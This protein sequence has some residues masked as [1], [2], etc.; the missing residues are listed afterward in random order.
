[1]RLRAFQQRF[2][3]GALKPECRTAVLSLPRGNGK[4]SLVAM[5]AE[6]CLTP[7]DRLHVPG[8]E[9][10]IV[11]GSLGQARRTT[12]RLLKERMVDRDGY[13]IA[14]SGQACHVYH[15][16]SDCRISVLPAN[17]RGAQGLV[18]APWVFADDCGSWEANGGL[19]MYDAIQTSMGKPD[20]PMTAIYT[21]TIAP[22]VRGWWPELATSK[23]TR[24]TFVMTLQADL[25]KWDSLRELRRV[26]PLLWQFPDSRAVVKDELQKAKTDSRLR[27]RFLSY[28]ANLPTPDEASVLLPLS[29]WAMVLK[30]P[31]PPPDDIGAFVG[32]DVGSSR[33]WSAACATWLSGRAEAFAM[34]GGI[35]SLEARERRD[36]VPR[37]LYA[38]LARSGALVVQPERRTV[39]MK[40]FAEEIA[41]RWDPIL[42]TAD[43][44]RFAALKDECDFPLV[45]ADSPWKSH[46][47]GIACLRTAALDGDMA[48][49]LDSRDLLEFSISVSTITPDAFGTERLVKSSDSRE[50]DDPAT[51]LVLAMGLAESQRP[52]F[53][54]EVLEGVIV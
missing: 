12:F 4:S 19:E 7:G 25:T 43:S 5:L 2:L 52:M 42:A 40:A 18:R 46:G 35:P 17:S 20:S 30:R 6:R 45:K 3:R 33:S 11:S 31:V 27:S 28:R 54:G 53:E 26:N 50:R 41:K 39:N 8:T 36:K 15:K 47:E 49:A 23:S 22:N 38:A 1:M 48:V 44:Y 9:S 29:D 14:E 10:H 34:V 37:G 24:T 16:P 21:G 13:R 51:A 32:I